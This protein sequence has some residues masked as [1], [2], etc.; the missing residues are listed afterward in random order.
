[1]TEAVV[2]VEELRAAIEQILAAVER[3]HG[4]SVTLDE[5]Y[6]WH[7]PVEAAYDMSAAPEIREVGQVSDDLA[8]MR[9]GLTEDGE[10]LSIWHALSHVI[11]VLRV[12]EKLS[13][14]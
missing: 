2:Q 9:N 5:D 12:F 3:T 1:M 11:G 10:V 14:P 7:L 8:E 6:Y 4:S 13:L